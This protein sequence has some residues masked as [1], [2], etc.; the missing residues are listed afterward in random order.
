MQ[1]ID[2]EKI[3]TKFRIQKNYHFAKIPIY[4]FYSI[5][6]LFIVNICIYILRYQLT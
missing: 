5:V 6:M 2:L 1:K 4:I 3:W